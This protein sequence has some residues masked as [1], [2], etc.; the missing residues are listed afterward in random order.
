MKL[1]LVNQRHGH[2]KTIV[3]KGWVKGLLSVCLL[4]A[5]VALGYIGYQL[6]ISDNAFVLTEDTAHKWQQRLSLQKSDL[7]ELKQ[8]SK[9][10][11]EALSLRL[12]MMQARLARLDAM[13][14]RIT[15]M[16]DFDNGEFDFSQPIVTVGGP[17]LDENEFSESGFL[18][19]LS[20]LE[21]QLEDRQGQ[22]QIL[23]DL[24]DDRK[25][26]SEVFIAGRPIEQGWIASRFGQRPDPFTGR[27]SFHAGIDFTTGRAG[28]E[29]NTVASG[30][31]T[32]SGPRSGYG[33]MVEVNHG[34]GF[35]TRYAHAEKL[36]VDVGDIVDKGQNIALVGST[37][38]STG[39]HVHF[40]V[41][42]NG[43]VVD[44]AAYIHRTVR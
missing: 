13:G 19:A 30:V 9:R 40:E 24:L 23:E 31:V 4:G 43:R 10:E 27:M 42:K 35:T 12:A 21:R 28:A 38:R 33:L 3:I 8:E 34:N 32:W 1:I 29:I 20:G 14:E 37:G 39:P 11:L 25:I 18:S 17:A 6:A 7:E 26:Q 15:G 41:Y 5:P 16:T 44:P 2:T 22:L 36:L